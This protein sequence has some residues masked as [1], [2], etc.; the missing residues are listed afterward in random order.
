LWLKDWLQRRKTT[1][2]HSQQKHPAVPLKVYFMHFS[3][4]CG[5]VSVSYW[6]WCFILLVHHHAIL[7]CY[8][9][10]HLNLWTTWAVRCFCLEQ[11][12]SW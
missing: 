8:V 9:N 2:S 10:C 12:H 1:G 5:N 4:L 11:I 7:P 3:V 6:N